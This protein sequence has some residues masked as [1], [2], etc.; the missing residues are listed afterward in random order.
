MWARKAFSV[1]VGKLLPATVATFAVYFVMGIWHGATWQ[2]FVFGIF[3]GLII[4][5]SQFL[6][7]VFKKIRS[8]VENANGTKSPGTDKDSVF[9]YV[10]AVIRTFVIML[11]LR[12]FVR[13]S[14]IGGAFTMLGRVFIAPRVGELLNGTLFNLGLSLADY[15]VLAVGIIVMFAAEVA[16]ERGTD[17]FE[18][19]DKAPVLLQ[20]ALLLFFLGFITVFGLYSGGASSAAFIYGQF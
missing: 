3:N 19:N 17:I 9:W 5:A 12:V 16:A 20:G 15:A 18:L 13:A 4:S 1:R 10:F 2:G 6:E 7:P 11:F 8:N 14:S